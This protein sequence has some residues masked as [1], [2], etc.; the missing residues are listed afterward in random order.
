MR[1]WFRE[2]SE[3]FYSRIIETCSVLVAIY[4]MRLHG[5]IKHTIKIQTWRHYFLDTFHAVYNAM[6]QKFVVAVSVW[7]K[8]VDMEYWNF[9]V[10]SEV[11][12]ELPFVPCQLISSYSLGLPGPEDEGGTIIVW[13]VS[14]YL[15]NWCGITSHRWIFSSITVETPKLALGWELFHFL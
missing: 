6:S 12:V 7:I 2:Q 15:T 3:D 8:T 10:Q 5:K 11:Y 13:N 4:Q 14:N 9:C 1:K